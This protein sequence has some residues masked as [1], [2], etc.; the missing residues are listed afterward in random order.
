[1]AWIFVSGGTPQSDWLPFYAS[2]FWTVEI[3]GS[4]YGT[5]SLETVQAWH[6][7]TP[8]GFEFA[9]KASKFITHWKRLSD[10]CENSIA[11]MESEAFLAERSGLATATASGPSLRFWKPL[12]SAVRKPH[13]SARGVSTRSFHVPSR[14]A[15]PSTAAKLAAKAPNSSAAV[16]QN[17]RC[18]AP[19]RVLS[20]VALASAMT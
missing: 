12:S 19:R 14:S 5:P 7:H 2:R 3:N 17:D 18:A 4:F 20:A 16:S 9:W 1:M 6:D 11:L 10:K 15:P 13:H 8:K